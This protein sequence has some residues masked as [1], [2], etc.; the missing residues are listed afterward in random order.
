M[1]LEKIWLVISFVV[2]FGCGKESAKTV[3]DNP[4][5]V[6]PAVNPQTPPSAEP[7]ATFVE[8]ADAAAAAETEMQES[9]FQ[10]VVQGLSIWQDGAV[11]DSKVSDFIGVAE[12]AV[13]AFATASSTEAGKYAELIGSLTGKVALVKATARADSEAMAV[14][15]AFKLREFRKDQKS[16]LLA[17]CEVSESNAGQCL[18]TILRLKGDGQTAR[19]KHFAE[20]ANSFFVVGRE[21]YRQWGRQRSFDVFYNQGMAK[22]DLLQFHLPAK[23][24]NDAAGTGFTFQI[25]GLTG[26]MA[27]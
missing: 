6:I 20:E 14:A 18:Q 26:A 11:Y 17:L 8:L 12:K 22:R 9:T 27:L 3:A 15:N 24:A 16:V 23:F 5:K 10:N 2:L 21:E 7:K 4:G 1:T 13:D 25:P 19:L